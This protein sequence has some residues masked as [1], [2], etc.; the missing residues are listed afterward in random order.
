MLPAGRRLPAGAHSE[1]LTKAS[2]AGVEVLADEFS[3][4]ERG[5]AAGKLVAGVR[6]VPLDTVVDQLARPRDLTPPSV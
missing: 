4:R 1:L 3:L 5:I 6:A 2:E